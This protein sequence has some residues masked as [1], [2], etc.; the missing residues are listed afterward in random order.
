MFIANFNSI[1]YYIRIVPYE[2]VCADSKILYFS[3]AEICLYCGGNHVV[4]TTRKN[5]TKNNMYCI[6]TDN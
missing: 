2:N 5:L 4:F 3:R 6:I 1:S